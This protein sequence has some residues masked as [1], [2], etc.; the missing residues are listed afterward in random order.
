M[1]STD[2]AELQKEPY[3]H[4]YEPSQMKRGCGALAFRGAGTGEASDKGGEDGVKKDEL[5]S[6]SGFFGDD[7]SHGNSW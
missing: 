7:V 2:V 6:E 4:R 1:D 3:G 5:E